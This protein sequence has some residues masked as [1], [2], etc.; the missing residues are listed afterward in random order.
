M[1]Q[2]ASS[3]FFDS[4][5]WSGAGLSVLGLFGLIW[6]IT[7]VWRARRAQFDEDTMRALLQRIVPI[8]LGALFVS[9]LGL[10]LVILGIFLR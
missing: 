2:T 9:V 4:L 10:I 1:E 7:K 8:N 5:V 3:S 6:C